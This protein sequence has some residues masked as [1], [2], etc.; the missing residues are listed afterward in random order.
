VAGSRNRD[1]VEERK[2]RLSLRDRFALTVAEAAAAIGVSPRFFR[3]ILPDV[4]HLHLGKRV[5]IPTK[6][7]EEWLRKRAQ[8]EQSSIDATVD[9]VLSSLDKKI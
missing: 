7:F 8:E 3:D 6:P 5:L 2:E 9:A 4:P 1:S